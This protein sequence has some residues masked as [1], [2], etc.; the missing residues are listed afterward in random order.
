MT[1]GNFGR[2]L[3]QAGAA[4]LFALTI[5]AVAP[6]SAAFAAAGA[7]PGVAPLAPNM[8]RIWFYRDYEP[9]ESL[10]RPYVRLNGAVAGISEPGEVFYRD[11]A[12]GTYSVTVDS[13]GTD[14]DQFAS[15]A[16]APGQQVFVKV[17]ADKNW[18]SG[19][20]GAF[21][22]GWE[23]DTFY[24][25]QMQPQAAAAAIAQMPLYDGS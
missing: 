2:R 10:A 25:W 3:Q 7:A 1:T 19:G 14:T 24:T 9:Y 8:A 13:V 15:V 17:L 6:S 23:R 22:N 21:G 20:G 12:P 16:V 11:V 4:L 5:L 18:D